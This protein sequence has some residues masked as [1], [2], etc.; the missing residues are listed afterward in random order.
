MRILVILLMVVP[1]AAAADIYECKITRKV[2][3][4]G[5]DSPE[6]LKKW[7]PSAILEINQNGPSY[8]SRCSYSTIEKKVTCDRYEMDRVDVDPYV[9]HIKMYRFRSQMTV[10]LFA[11]L[12]F[13]E[14]V[15]RGI[16]SFGKCKALTP[17]TTRDVK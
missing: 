8:A 5:E 17:P 16:V 13:M 3:A 14:D 7:Q 15:G 1:L 9:G 11:N 4:T 10:Q 2:Y 12:N 6:E